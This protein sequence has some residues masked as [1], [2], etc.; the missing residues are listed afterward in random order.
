MTSLQCNGFGIR[1]IL[2][3]LMLLLLAGCTGKTRPDITK[4]QAQVDYDLLHTLPSEP[5]DYG[6]VQPILERRCVVCHGCYDA[7]CQLKLSSHE[8][9]M[10]GANPELVYNGARIKAMEPTRLFID[11]KSAAE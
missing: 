5:I 7:P 4:K 2:P 11:A 1:L 8:G 3:L 9:L 6:R 10:R